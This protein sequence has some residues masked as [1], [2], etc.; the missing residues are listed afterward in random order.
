M[1]IENDMT[2]E[3][4]K[5]EILLLQSWKVRRPT[6]FPVA[7]TDFYINVRRKTGNAVGSDILSFYAHIMLQFFHGR[8]KPT[9]HNHWYAFF[10]RLSFVTEAKA[11][12]WI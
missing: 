9:K 5:T 7:F 6:F 3:Y 12:L 1:L 8:I 4:R 10:K 11:A 2:D